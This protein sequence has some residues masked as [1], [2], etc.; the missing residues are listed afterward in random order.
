MC[1]RYTLHQETKNIAKRFKERHGYE[2]IKQVDEDSNGKIHLS[3]GALYTSIKQ[4]LEQKLVIEVARND[5]TRRRYYRLSD[6]G[7]TIL[8]E[9]LGYYQNTIALARER[10]ILEIRNGI[11]C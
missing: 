9:E 1:G 10:Q 3:P 8:S 4:L 2:V 6:K 7:K 5:D 11:Y